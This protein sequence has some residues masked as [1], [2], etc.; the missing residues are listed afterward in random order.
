MMKFTKLFPADIGVSSNQQKRFELRIPIKRVVKIHLHSLY[1]YL[2][3]KQ[4]Q[5]DF[6]MLK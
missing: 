5:H 2:L 6:N 4:Y 1:G 3:K